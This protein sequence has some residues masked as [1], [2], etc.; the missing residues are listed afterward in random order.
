MGV[1]GAPAAGVQAA[2]QRAGQGRHPAA[3]RGTAP[4]AGPPCSRRA[5]MLLAARAA[6]LLPCRL[7]M[8]AQSPRCAWHA[9]HLMHGRV[10]KHLS[11]T[12]L[13]DLNI[14]ALAAGACKC[15]ASC[16]YHTCTVSALRLLHKWVSLFICLLSQV[17]PV[18]ACLSRLITSEERD[19]RRGGSSKTSCCSRCCSSSTS[20]PSSLP[21]KVATRRSCNAASLLLPF[22]V[23]RSWEQQACKEVKHL[24]V[25]A[26]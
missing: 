12:E 7:R 3:T 15:K 24:Q 4:G 8:Q 17:V 13:P 10:D 11:Q 20:I 9:V 23:Q 2:A 25:V 16:T 1:R 22:V 18:L 6:C 21:A 19:V 26:P 14:T 5:A